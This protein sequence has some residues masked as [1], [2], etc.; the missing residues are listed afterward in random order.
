M[1]G[2]RIFSRMVPL[3]GITTSITIQ[4]CHLGEKDELL[5]W[6]KHDDQQRSPQNI[7][8]ADDFTSGIANNFFYACIN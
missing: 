1:V 3:E 7:P 5:G 4:V 6:L 2:M 8:K